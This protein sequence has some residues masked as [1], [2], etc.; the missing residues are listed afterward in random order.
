MELRYEIEAVAHWR[1]LSTKPF[2]NAAASPARLE[3]ASSCLLGCQRLRRAGS[4]LVWP[5][6]GA[7]IRASLARP[8]HA[9]LGLGAFLFHFFPLGSRLRAAFCLGGFGVLSLR[10]AVG[11][12][13]PRRTG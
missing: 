6:L 8:T 10:H 13:G 4:P 5:S 11:L 3:P 9:G 12:G 7:F 2:T 1:T